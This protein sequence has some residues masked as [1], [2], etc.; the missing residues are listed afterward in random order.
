MDEDRKLMLELKAGNRGA[1]NRLVDKYSKPIINYIYRFTASREDA[2]DLT[3]DVFIKVYNAAASYTPSAKFTTWIYRIASNISIDY[4]RKR[5]H[6]KN[7]SSLDEKIDTGEGAME[8]QE[9]DAKIIPSDKIAENRETQEEINTA[10]QALPENQRA[11][12]ILKV[13][14]D[15]TYAEIAQVLGVSVPSVESLIFRA[16]TFLKKVL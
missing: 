16:R 2:E 13:Y 12:I 6:E 4:I 10:L 3:Q 8:K 15:S 1:F 9:E 11:A 5:K 7:G 14:E